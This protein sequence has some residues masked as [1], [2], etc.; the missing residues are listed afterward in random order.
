MLVSDS[1]ESE[2]DS[3]NCDTNYSLEELAAEVNSVKHSSVFSEFTHT[4]KD[5]LKARSHDI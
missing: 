5:R 4:S 3:H 2:E 1:D